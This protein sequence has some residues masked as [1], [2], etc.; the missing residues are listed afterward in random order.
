M[1]WTRI[2]QERLHED[3]PLQDSSGAS[4]APVFCFRTPESQV[5]PLLGITSDTDRKM[6]LA[7]FPVSLEPRDSS[8]PCL[9]WVPRNIKRTRKDQ[10]ISFEQLHCVSIWVTEEGHGFLWTTWKPAGWEGQER[11]PGEAAW[12]PGQWVWECG[13]CP[14]P[15]E[16]VVGLWEG[17]CWKQRPEPSREG[18]GPP[19]RG[20]LVSSA[21]QWE[22]LRPACW[23][24]AWPICLRNIN[25]ENKEK[26]ETGS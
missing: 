12:G 11:I 14:G 4:W 2:K 5:H 18:P 7:R 25:W 3:V 22:L 9:R 20:A 21:E 26:L 8:H 17:G 6:R 19:G 23:S 10:S 15:S 16:Q 24:P 1:Q 13:P